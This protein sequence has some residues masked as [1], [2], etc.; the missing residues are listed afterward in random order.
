MSPFLPL[1]ES[2]PIGW[3]FSPFF[4][5]DCTLVQV[6]IV[7]WQG[8]K[9][10]LCVFHQLTDFCLPTGK[11]PFGKWNCWNLKPRFPWAMKGLFAKSAVI[12][13]LSGKAFHFPIYQKS[14]SCVRMPA[15]R[16]MD[17]LMEMWVQSIMTVATV[18]HS[19][20][21][22]SQKKLC[23]MERRNEKGNLCIPF[24]SAQPSMQFFITPAFIER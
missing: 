14:D 15:K 23:C 11:D 21:W 3:Y 18:R 22:V 13:A 5:Q 12:L 24:I 8:V 9:Y 10:L 7:S 20:F 4:S 19:F 6:I 16:W 17:S 2:K 1:N